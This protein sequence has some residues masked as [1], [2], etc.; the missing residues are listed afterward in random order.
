MSHAG[1]TPVFG[2]ATE[3]EPGRFRSTLELTMAGD[4]H[5]LVHV[6]LSDGR[7]VE[8]QFEIKGVASG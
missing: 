4:W 3:I 8:R 7:Q 2:E 6:T 5:V 1:M